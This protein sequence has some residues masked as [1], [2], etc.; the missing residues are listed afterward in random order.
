MSD[1]LTFT[2]A[3]LLIGGG[4]TAF[5][6]LWAALQRRLLGVP[7][8]NYALVG[9][10]IGHLLRGRFT[11]RSIADAP[12]VR[13]EA[14]LGWIAHY[15]TGI[16]F[17]AVLLTVWG[18]QWAHNP[19]P[20]PALLVGVATVVA[21]FLILQPGM[22]AGIAASKTPQPN[23]SRFRS[24]VAHVSFGIGLYGAAVLAAAVLP[25]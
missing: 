25:A 22:G 13:G 14:V 8:L 17:A 21:P 18:V 1:V 19:T 6:D 11:H 10:W 23:R 9:R 4:A 20:G 3:A 12:P 2:M 7:S 5:M 16:V 24:L 15:A